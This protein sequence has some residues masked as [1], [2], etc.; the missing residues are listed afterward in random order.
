MYINN[1]DTFLINSMVL[2][3]L[4]VTQKKLFN[5]M[6][7]HSTNV[8]ENNSFLLQYTSP[9][10]QKLLGILTCLERTDTCLIFLDR[11]TTAKMLY[12]YIKV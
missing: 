11:C 10:L 3:E 1:T 5:Y 9:K 12:H 4:T 7:K 8:V 6:I 2:S